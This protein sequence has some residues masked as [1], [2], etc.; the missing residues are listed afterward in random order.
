MIGNSHSPTNH[1]PGK[2]CKL[3]TWPLGR[4]VAKISQFI[5]TPTEKV[6]ILPCA[7]KPT[8]YVF[9]YNGFTLQK[10]LESF[11]GTIHAV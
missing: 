4:E 9:S 7:D 1:R 2:S 3:T 5:R 11:I 10:R 6:N 8:I